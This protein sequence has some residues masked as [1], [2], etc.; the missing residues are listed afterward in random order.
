[1]TREAFCWRLTEPPIH[2]GDAVEVALGLEVAR[3]GYGL[4]EFDFARSSSP[5]G[6]LVLTLRCDGAGHVS[7]PLSLLDRNEQAIPKAPEHLPAEARRSLEAR[8]LEVLGR[9]LFDDVAHLA[10]L[11]M[12][13][14]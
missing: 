13:S 2:E 1:M 6:E 3:L 10:R 7:E 8:Y 14:R 9:A 5:S 12:E 11:E 4:L